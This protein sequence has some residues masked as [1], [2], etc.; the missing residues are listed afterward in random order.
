MANY[1]AFSST[2]AASRK[3]M[4]WPEIEYFIE[5]TKKDDQK[6]T[7]KILDVGC[8]SGRLCGELEKSGI[9]HEYLG[10]DASSGMIEE[11]KKALPEAKFEVLDMSNLDML[12]TKFDA[13]FFLASFHH[14]E[15]E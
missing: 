7:L 10:I 8:G 3:N 14:L 11:A 1:D 13:V 2:F 15:S 12:D 5:L 4:R 9:V 6:K